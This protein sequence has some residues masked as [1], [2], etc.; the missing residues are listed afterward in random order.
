MTTTTTTTDAVQTGAYI[1]EKDQ[2]GEED[3]MICDPYGENLF[4]Y[5]HGWLLCLHPPLLFSPAIYHH[6]CPCSIYYLP[7]IHTL[8]ASTR[9]RHVT[10]SRP[11]LLSV[12]RCF[13]DLFWFLK[14]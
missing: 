2:E 11:L 8:S 13:S 4:E 10:H 12:D 7:S 14:P 5:S 9:Q 6:D 3:M 1:A